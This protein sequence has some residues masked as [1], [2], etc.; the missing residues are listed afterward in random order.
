MPSDPTAGTEIVEVSNF[1]EAAMPR[2]VADDVGDEVAVVDVA[3]VDSEAVGVAD[4]ATAGGL[5]TLPVGF[6]TRSTGADSALTHTESATTTAT[7]AAI[8]QA[9]REP[10]H[11][12]TR[13]QGRGGW[14]TP[15]P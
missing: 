7:P 4:V 6:P 8:A 5:E 12:G 1:P 14:D 3:L 15:S 9:S 2:E 11:G 10:T 13:S